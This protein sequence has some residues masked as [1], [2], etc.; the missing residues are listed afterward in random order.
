MEIGY[1]MKMVNYG[2][3]FINN[4][5]F[6]NYLNIYNYDS[7]VVD[8][9]GFQDPATPIME[10]IIDLHHDLFFFLV[11][12][13]VFVS[14]LLIITCIK[15]FW[16]M[17]FS[18]TYY[19]EFTDKLDT[20]TTFQKNILIKLNHFIKKHD[21]I[22]TNKILRAI[23]WRHLAIGAR[24]WNYY[25]GPNWVEHHRQHDWYDQDEQFYSHLTFLEIVWTI[26]PSLILLI[27]ALPSFALLYAMDEV[28]IPNVTVKAIGHQWYWT[29]EYSDNLIRTYKR[30][31]QVENNII[32]KYKYRILHKF[33]SYMVTEEDL[34]RI[35]YFSENGIRLL[36]NNLE[37]NSRFMRLLDVDNRMVLPLRE[38]IRLLVTS[39]DVLH[40]WAVPSLGVKIDACPGRLNQTSIFIKRE[41]VFYGQCSELCGI[42]H[43]FM[44]IVIVCV[45]P[46]LYHDH[47]DYVNEIW[48]W[49][50]AVYKPDI[51]K[52]PYRNFFYH[53]PL[54]KINFI[55]IYVSRFKH[56]YFYNWLEKNANVLEII[57]LNNFSNKNTN[58]NN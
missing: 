4:F 13:S 2:K 7:P 36:E 42:N 55:S 33:D 30:S 29:Y 57:K 23:D 20:F 8:Q 46:Y 37:Q 15:H 53:I 56:F 22:F 6:N 54:Y 52:F 48:K 5:L 58:I 32:A 41:G 12:I 18:L 9:I 16:K 39:D 44:P 11:L 27:I 19:F 38:N 45:S 50:T 24:K 34:V 28:L 51:I 14:W 47:E 31:G 10:G 17:R 49:N 35:R 40:S 3:N 21:K 25:K 1:L 26:I 43:A